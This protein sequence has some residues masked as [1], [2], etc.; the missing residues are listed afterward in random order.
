MDSSS[1]SVVITG[2][3]G[4]IGRH[5]LETIRDTHTVI[6]IARRSAREAGIPDHPNVHW[7]QWD[8]GGMQSFDEVRQQIVRLGG[9]DFLFHLAAFYDFNYSDDLAYERTNITGTRNV[10]RLAT[11]LH[12]KRFVFASSLAACN[13][14]RPGTSIT[15]QTPVDANFAY[16]RTKKAGE[17]M[18]RE[19]SG[20]MASTIIRFAAV[21][22]DWC[23]YPPLY[24]FLETWLSRKYDSRILGGKGESAV[25][26]IHIS[27]LVKIFQVIMQKSHLLPQFDIYAAS[28]DGSTSHRELFELATHDF[29][30]TDVKPVFLPRLVAFPGI[31]LRN[32]MGYLHLTPMPFEKLWMLKYLDLK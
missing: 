30:G 32:L 26:Y 18:V 31:L 6:A 23:E 22:S 14:P 5:F 28:P 8:I 1:A 25:P 11:E 2:A 12:V 29:F 9:A 27:D 16:A 3:S 24:K 10:I 17:E 7:I 15:E 20:D 4:F 21:F 19:V 13:F